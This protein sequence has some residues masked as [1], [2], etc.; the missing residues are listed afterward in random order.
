MSFWPYCCR[1]N[2]IYR[3][4]INH[5]IAPEPS[6]DRQPRQF[7]GGW[8]GLASYPQVAGCPDAS[9]IDGQSQWIV[10]DSQHAILEDG[11]LWTWGETAWAHARD[12]GISLDT[13]ALNSGGI[14]CGRSPV[15]VGS[16]TGWTAVSGQ[17]AMK[18]T[19]LY[20]FGSNK[21]GRLG[22]GLAPSPGDGEWNLGKTKLAGGFYH[23]VISSGVSSVQLF[24]TTTNYTSLPSLTV[25]ARNPLDINGVDLPAESGAGAVLTPEWY[26]SVVSVSVTAGGTEYASAPTIAFLPAGKGDLSAIATV[27]DG[28]LTKV[29]ITGSDYSWQ[30]IPTVEITGGGG[31]NAVAVCDKISGPMTGVTVTA[32]GGG[33]STTSGLAGQRLRRLYCVVNGQAAAGTIALQASGVT[34]IKGPATGRIYSPQINGKTYIRAVGLGVVDKISGFTLPNAAGDIDSTGVGSVSVSTPAGVTPYSSVPTVQFWPKAATPGGSGACGTAIVENGVVTSVYITSPGSG[35]AA[36]PDV[37]ISGGGGP[38]WTAYDPR[39]GVVAIKVTSSGSYESVPTVTV[40]DV[41]S[42]SMY[43]DENNVTAPLGDDPSM[44]PVSAYAV[45]TGYVNS[46]AL[47]T[48]GSGY[49]ASPLPTVTIA[50]PPTG[51]ETRTG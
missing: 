3:W 21:D 16:D 18:G 46:L 22:I 40:Y 50:P 15:R 27:A 5:S 51:Y 2:Q 11:S 24:S 37:F 35:Y 23:S 14:T 32:T 10:V 6:S 19:A 28:K 49:A 45:L 17:L 42:L 34:E 12:Q 9:Q 13:T 30:A 31:K 26:G 43:T 47:A 33:Y 29:T 7:C 4:Q 39:Y 36:P 48:G 41:E 20:S 1:N 38:T 8:D 44:V 25:V